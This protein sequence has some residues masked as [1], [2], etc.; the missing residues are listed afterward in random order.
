MVLLAAPPKPSP[1]Y[2][3]TIE[4]LTKLPELLR[5]RRDKLRLSN[6]TQAAQIGIAQ[7]TLSS[8]YTG[9]NPSLSTILACLRWLATH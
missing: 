5:A 2:P 4:T 6:K 7:Y 3:V 8:L 9:S 1:N